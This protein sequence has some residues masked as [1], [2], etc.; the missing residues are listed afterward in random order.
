MISFVEFVSY[1][2]T[3]LLIVF[4]SVSYAAGLFLLAQWAEEYPTNT[5]RIIKYVIAAVFA[6]DVAAIPLS[7]IHFVPL[8]I[9]AAVTAAYAGTMLQTFPLISLTAA[10]VAT[11]LASVAVQIMWAVYFA[12]A[13]VPPYQYAQPPY[14]TS[15]LLAFQ[16]ISVWAAPALFF[17]TATLTQTLP[18]VHDVDTDSQRKTSKARWSVAAIF[19]AFRRPTANANANNPPSPPPT[20][21]PHVYHNNMWATRVRESSNQAST[22]ATWAPTLTPQTSRT[23][24][25]ANTAP[26]NRMRSTPNVDYQ[27]TQPLMQYQS[28]TEQYAPMVHPP[29]TVHARQRSY[30]KD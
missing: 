17:V 1:I 13:N 16:F 9:S 27:S 2:F 8:L 19:T 22:A 29:T 3:V 20:P 12:Y 10:N 4:T 24:S 15:Q 7:N 21:P 11:A 26:I 23:E 18:T 25:Y 5:K 14:T 28:D 6:V 30:H